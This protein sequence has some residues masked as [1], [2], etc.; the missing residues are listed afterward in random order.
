MKKFSPYIFPLL[1]L[2][3]VFLLVLR[4]Y[5][6]RTDR[7]ES[8]LLGEGVV[9]ENLSEEEVASLEGVGD[10][11]TIELEKVAENTSGVVRY[12]VNDGKVTFTVSANLPGKEGAQYQVWLKEV[13]SNTTRHAFD[14]NAKKGGYI[15][16]AA[17]SAE[18]L[19]LEVIVR[20]AQ[21]A[22]DS[23]EQ[24]LLKGV[25]TLPEASN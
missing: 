3:V 20:E 7:M 15:G 25:I 21:P 13:N 11:E 16:S 6:L 22:T 9:I 10:Y 24:A 14:L 4:W 5:N 19:P 12:D 23:G 2:G 1:V 18:L 8:G 17:L